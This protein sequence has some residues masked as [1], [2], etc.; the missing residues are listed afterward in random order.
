MSHTIKLPS[1]HTAT[2]RDPKTL[3]HKD[4]VKALEKINESRNA[5]T[6]LEAVQSALISM[7]VESWTLDDPIPS[8]K[9]ESLGELDLG[10]YDTLALEA[11]KAQKILNISFSN[12]PEN[13]ANPD[14]PLD[15]SSD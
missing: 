10:D 4:R 3:K 8:I 6:A 15:N 14:S 1:G 11:D 5:Y 12:T 2:I 13:E 9:I 7:L